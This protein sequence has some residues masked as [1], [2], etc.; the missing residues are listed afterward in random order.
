MPNT[1]AERLRN[2]IEKIL[3][4]WETRALR[5]VAAAKH[6]ESLALRNS[7]PRY[8]NLLANA[9]STTIDRTSARKQ[10][11]KFENALT[12]KKHGGD[13]AISRNYSTDQLITE[14]HILRQVLCDVLEEKAPLTTVEREVIVSSIEQAVNDAATEFN[15]VLKSFQDRMSHTIAHDLRNPITSTKIS[16]EIVL[17]KLAPADSS[18]SKLKLIISNMDR[19]DQM[20]KELLDANR[21]R[22]GEAMPVNINLCDLN[23]I[24]RQV[25][26]EL[27]LSYPNS[28]KVQSEGKCQGY[29]D[30][31]GLRRILENL[32]TNAIKYGNEDSFITISL[33]QDETFAEL[34]V[35]NFGKAIAP[36][37]MS[38][39]F[40]QYR[41]LKSSPN[42]AGWGLGLTLVKGVVDALQGSIDVES[43]KNKGTTFKIKLPKDA[44][45]SMMSEI[46]H[47]I[48]KP[49][50]VEEAPQ[51]P[52]R[53]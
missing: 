46:P 1:T 38:I 4:I 36:E 37:E 15:K 21:L 49:S 43:D 32:I 8:L 5:E 14:Y 22:A 24:I 16:A 11:D 50:H 12:S 26:D 3:S 2:N 18:A 19:L 39:L 48:E 13:R 52:L 27:S 23:A 17:K 28:L 7:L 51:I 10:S 31:N 42:R 29:W 40:E 44:R 47:K 35:H 34:S 9:L 53:E 30:E 25:T 33:S 45:S 6:Q 41:R 20:I